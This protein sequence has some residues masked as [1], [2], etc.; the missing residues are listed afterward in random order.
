[1]CVLYQLKAAELAQTER[2]S[3]LTHVNSELDRQRHDCDTLRD[4]LRQSQVTLVCF[5]VHS[6]LSFT[7][8]ISAAVWMR[9]STADVSVLNTHFTNVFDVR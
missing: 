7:A 9:R 6:R 3:Q 8:L 5:H 2:G 1:M 4:K